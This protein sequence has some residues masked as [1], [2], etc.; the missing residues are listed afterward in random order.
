[1]LAN[2]GATNIPTVSSSFL[3]EERGLNEWR[4]ASAREKT[5]SECSPPPCFS[6]FFELDRFREAE[7]S[8]DFS[9]QISRY[10]DISGAK[11]FATNC[12]LP[13]EGFDAC[14]IF[15]YI[16][17]YSSVCTNTLCILYCILYTVQYCT[18]Y[19]ITAHTRNVNRYEVHY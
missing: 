10:V 2:T 3:L 14:H 1:M 12:Q 15:N 18:I 11:E 13:S 19:R 8:G 9:E 16:R 7:E 5:P 6:F 17:I 4:R